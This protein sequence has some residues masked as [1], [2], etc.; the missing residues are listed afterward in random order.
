M[1]DW[2]NALLISIGANAS[3]ASTGYFKAKQENGK[4]TFEPK[5]WLKTILIAVIPPAV[6]F[7]LEQV[8]I[9]IPGADFVGLLSPALDK[10]LGAFGL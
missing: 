10:L 5:R 1:T 6:L 4:T 2:L 8:G 7:M 3:Y 9:V